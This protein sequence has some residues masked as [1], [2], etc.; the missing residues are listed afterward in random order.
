MLNIG[1]QLSDA[2]AAA[3]RAGIIH[4][5]LRPTNVILTP[6]SVKV[7]DFGLAKLAAPSQAMG[8]S[9]SQSP[10]IASMTDRGIVIGHASLN[11]A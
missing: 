5:D 8:V 6:A 10:A 2:L 1:T 7:L 3:H 4:R 11:G 9:T